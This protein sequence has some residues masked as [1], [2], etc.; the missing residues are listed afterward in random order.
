M[1]DRFCGNIF[2][3]ACSAKSR[4]LLFLGYAEPVRICDSC[5]NTC[6]LRDDFM[7]VRKTHSKPS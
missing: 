3:H 5:M 7:E 2:C 6:N 1:C 4:A